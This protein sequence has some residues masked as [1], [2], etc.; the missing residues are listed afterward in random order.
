MIT[1][2]EA[3]KKLQQQE[4]WMS[5]PSIELVKECIQAGVDPNLLAW[6]SDYSYAKYPIL[7]YAAEYLPEAVPL[8]IEAG[9]DVNK[10]GYEGETPV[11]SAS[12]WSA[13]KPESLRYMLA[14]NANIKKQVNVTL[15]CSNPEGQAVLDMLKSQMGFCLPDPGSLNCLGWLLS[16]GANMYDDPDDKVAEETRQKMRMLFEAGIDPNAPARYNQAPIFS[17]TC[18]GYVKATEIILECGGNPNVTNREG[19]TVL[20]EIARSMVEESRYARVRK[21]L[22]MTTSQDTNW[23]TYRK[24]GDMLKLLFRYGADATMKNPKGESFLS[25]AGEFPFVQDLGKVL[26]TGDSEKVNDWFDKQ[27]VAY[28]KYFFNRWKEAVSSGRVSQDNPQWQAMLQ[29]KLQEENQKS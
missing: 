20:I 12:Y 1:K 9:A 5:K 2:Q 8:L 3:T 7:T 19:D 10:P 13:I 6:H 17:T 14:A 28:R 11:E 15:G 16:E 29:R 24:Y 4:F 22:G 27:S 26:Q 25:I 23:M 18:N 21:E